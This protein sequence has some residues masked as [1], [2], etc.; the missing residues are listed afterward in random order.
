MATVGQSFRCF[1]I[2]KHWASYGDSAAMSVSEV[3]HFLASSLHTSA[4]SHQCHYLCNWQTFD[5]STPVEWC[6]TNIRAELF[7]TSIWR[8]SVSCGRR[9]RG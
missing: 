7:M 2:S 1:P 5:K 9:W 3:V 4:C 6:H 8:G